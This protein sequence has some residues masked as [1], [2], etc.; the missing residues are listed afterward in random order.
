MISVIIPTWN[1]AS[2]IRQTL[3]RLF[4][5][6]GDF[7]VVIADGGSRDQTL[8]IAQAWPSVR[9]VHAPKGRA[10]QMNA[11]ARAAR[12]EWLL[13]LHADTLL[14]EEA[15]VSIHALAPDVEA[16]GFRHRFS[17]SGCSLWLISLVDNIRCHTTRII[18]GDQ[19]MFVRRT[20]FQRLGGFPDTDKLEDVLFC[21]RL[22]ET[23]R[24]VLLNRHVV[25]DARKFLAMGVWRSLGRVVVILLC[26]QLRRPIPEFALPFFTDVR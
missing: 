13:F 7:E 18:Y 1:E 5:Q 9:V 3:E 14:P 26:V 16:G 4:A 2:A 8:R 21:E 11:G 22:V 10:T 25:T 17:G 20:L 19:A 12:G 15:L 23:T 24:P 6:D